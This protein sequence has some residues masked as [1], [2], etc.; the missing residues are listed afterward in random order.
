MQDKLTL[1]I[2]LTGFEAMLQI[3]R[4][5]SSCLRCQLTTALLQL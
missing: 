5:V 3:A 2:G 1:D 4:T